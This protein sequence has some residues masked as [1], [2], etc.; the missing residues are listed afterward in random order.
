LQTSEWARD[1]WRFEDAVDRIK[2]AIP[3]SLRIEGQNPLLLLHRALSE[4]IHDLSDAACLQRAE[5]ARI[6]LTELSRRI[7]TVLQDRS[8]VHE[9]VKELMKLEEKR[10]S[11]EGPT[12][13]HK[14]EANTISPKPT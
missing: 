11:K 12:I 10:G 3:D 13:V 9:A 2:N 14:G 5:A 8:E 6:V 7:E 1:A 4:G